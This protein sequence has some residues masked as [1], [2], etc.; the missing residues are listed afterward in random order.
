[1]KVQFEWLKSDVY[2]NGFYHEKWDQDCIICELQPASW[3]NV[4][5]LSNILA[6]C[7]GRWRLFVESKEWARELLKL[8]SVF[9]VYVEEIQDKLMNMIH[10]LISFNSF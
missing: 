7:K 1:M 3:N 10:V 5:W 6:G 8:M 2:K 4:R 9:A